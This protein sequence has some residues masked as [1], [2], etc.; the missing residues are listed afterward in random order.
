MLIFVLVSCVQN[1]VGDIS[2]NNV[3]YDRDAELG[4]GDK[5]IMVSV[6]NDN[7]T[8]VFTIH[9]DKKNLGDALIENDLVSGEDG[10]YGLYIK[11]VNGIVADYDLDQTYWSLTKNGEYMTTGVSDTVISDGDC[12]ELTK[13]KG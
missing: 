8:I 10:P 6:I 3:T 5:T 4:S 13:M 1:K 2:S 11:K 12:Y 7:E 9:T